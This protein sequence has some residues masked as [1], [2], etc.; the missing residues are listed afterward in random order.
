MTE[1]PVDEKTAGGATKKPVLYV[2]KIL[3]EGVTGRFVMKEMEPLAAWLLGVLPVIAKDL[4]VT[5]VEV[6]TYD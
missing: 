1:H 4:V 2:I 3:P 5:A 6:P